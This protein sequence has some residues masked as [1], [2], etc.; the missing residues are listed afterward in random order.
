MKY[1]VQLFSV[2][3]AVKK[4]LNEALAAVARCGYENV[5]LYGGEFATLD[6]EGARAVKAA[7][8][9]NGLTVSGMHTNLTVLREHLDDAAEVIRYLGSNRLILAWSDPKTE[10]EAEALVKDLEQWRFR[11]MEKGV[12]LGY[13]NHAQEFAPIEGGRSLMDY[14]I[15]ETQVFLEIDTYWVYA[16]GEDPLKWMRR[17]FAESRLPVIHIKDGLADG[18]GKP[19]GLGTAPWR[20]VWACAKELGVDMVVESETQ[21]PSGEEE[22]RVCMKALK[23]LEGK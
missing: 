1:G 12:K 21:D 7:L 20:D 16:A 8:K 10:A 4:D 9:N 5:E 2:R 11:L 19:L 15:E 6:L 3:D 17:C 14:I 18:A 23:E 22:I 13:H